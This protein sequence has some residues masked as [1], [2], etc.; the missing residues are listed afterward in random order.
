M[1]LYGKRVPTALALASALGIPQPSRRRVI[2]VGE[3]RVIDWGYCS[4][5][6]TALN[7]RAIRNKYKQ[8]ELCRAV[9]PPFW[10]NA[11]DIP[12]EEYPILSRAFRHTQGRDIRKANTEDELCDGDFYVKFIPKVYEYRVHCL[13]GE[14]LCI[15]RKVPPEDQEEVPICWNTGS[16]YTNKT[17]IKPSNIIDRLSTMALACCEA[18]GHDF[19][20]VDIIRT[21][22]DKLYFLEVNSAPALSPRRLALY[23]EAI[24]R[25]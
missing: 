17:V 24:K 15:T 18:T 21:D 12:N 7:A 22:R 9:A 11:Q 19:G 3:S 2:P 1:Y 5:V 14:V 23:V 6:P 20:A 4:G 10:R 13:K 25:W 16:R 8:L